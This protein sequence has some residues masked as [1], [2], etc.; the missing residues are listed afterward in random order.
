MNSSAR[1]KNIRVSKGRRRRKKA[2]C[3]AGSRYAGLACIELTIGPDLA[4]LDKN[5]E[6]PSGRKAEA[7]SRARR[8]SYS[9]GDGRNGVYRMRMRKKGITCGP[10]SGRRAMLFSR[11]GGANWIGRKIV[12]QV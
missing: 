2:A 8:L 7:E 4:I 6:S 3:A 10:A 5:K 9:G 1:R 11:L 12:G